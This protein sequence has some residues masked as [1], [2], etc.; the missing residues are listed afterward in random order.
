MTKNLSALLASD[1][2][3]VNT[4]SPGSFLSEGM[5]GYL[6]SLPSDRNVDSDSLVDAM[7]VITEDYG[8]PALLGRAADPGEIGPLVAFLCS[9][10]NTYITGADINIDGGS[11]FT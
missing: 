3:L 7:R 5:K 6:R 9:P 2:I 1:Q 8:H 4:V 10:A 11:N